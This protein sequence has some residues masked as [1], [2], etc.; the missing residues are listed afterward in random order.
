MK[1]NLL[2]LVLVGIFTVGAAS[3]QEGIGLAGVSYE[4]FEQQVILNANFTLYGPWGIE[5]SG[6]AS[7]KKGTVVVGLSPWEFMWEVPLMD[8]LSMYLGFG[9]PLVLN[10]NFNTMDYD[11][12]L[13]PQ[14]HIVLNFFADS[15]YGL[16]L[17][18]RPGYLI[19]FIGN[20]GSFECQLG[21]AFRMPGSFLADILSN[22]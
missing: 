20:P 14:G 18:V 11:A 3:A 5:G 21:L 4:P 10:I 16:S 9:A 19:N 1:K 7:F 2:A 6:G 15:D 12:G 22:L 17:Y 8:S 13:R